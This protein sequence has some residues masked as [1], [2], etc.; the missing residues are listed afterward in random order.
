M[1]N[2]LTYFFVY[3]L[4]LF[5][6]LFN[7]VFKEPIDTVY[8]FLLDSEPKHLSYRN[9]SIAVN[10]K[11]ESWIE[12][13]SILMFCF[14]FS[15]LFCRIEYLFRYFLS[16][17]SFLLRLHPFDQIRI[18]FLH[19]LHFQQWIETC[20]LLIFQHVKFTF[21]STL[22]CNYV[23]CGTPLVPYLLQNVCICMAW[24][25]AWPKILLIVV[26]LST[27]ESSSSW[28]HILNY[29]LQCIWGFLLKSRN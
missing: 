24:K 23:W 9:E 2:K 21:D 11:K 18:F 22:L 28:F 29:F 20:S 12:R 26:Q 7:H 13:K 25:F 5:W 14:V 17:A 3:R 6:I 10:N 19:F 15:S 1:Y 8:Y 27:Y 4:L 16:D